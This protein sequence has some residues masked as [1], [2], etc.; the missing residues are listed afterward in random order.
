R[1]KVSLEKRPRR[2]RINRAALDRSKRARANIIER[3]AH[4]PRRAARLRTGAN[5]LAALQEGSERR[6]LIVH[7]PA[8]ELGESQRLDLRARPP[9][10]AVRDTRR[11]SAAS[12][13]ERNAEKNAKARLRH[14][15]IAR[16]RWRPASSSGHAK[17]H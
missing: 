10:H 6:S 13:R 9:Q 17:K 15:F 16:L 11:Q 3:R 1:L 5:C 8:V 7:R 4:R 2:A 12:Q 14:P